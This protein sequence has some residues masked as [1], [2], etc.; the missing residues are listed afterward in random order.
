MSRELQ[1][2]LARVS[3]F[4][5][6]AHKILATHESTPSRVVVLE[7]TYRRLAKLS[8]KQDELLRQSLRCAESSLFRASHVMAWAAFMDFLEEKVSAGKL[9]KLHEIRPA[10]PTRSIEELREGVPEHQIVE[11]TRDLGL[12]TKNETKALLGLLNKRNE[13]AHPNDFYPGLNETIGYV[14]EIINRISQLQPRSI[15]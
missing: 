7:E 1:S 8:L 9:A 15:P 4:E 5:R 11:A 12:C 13:C 14:A 6:E 2:L 10:W 3:K